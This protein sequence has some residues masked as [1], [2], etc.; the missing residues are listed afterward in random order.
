MSVHEGIEAGR[1]RVVYSSLGY[2]NVVM[3]PF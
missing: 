3:S 1:M 2:T